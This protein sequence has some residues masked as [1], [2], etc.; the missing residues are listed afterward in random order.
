[1][2]TVS[3]QVN[4][5]EARLREAMLAGDLEMLD[6]LLADDLVFT[7]HTGHRMTKADDLATHKSGR[8]K[9]ERIDISDQRVRP[10]GTGAVVTL[11]AEVAGAYD[12]Q[13]FSATFAYTR[14]WEATDEHWRVAAAH[15]SAIV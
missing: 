8:L 3:D 4:A 5:M 1:M 6:A 11:V 2:I 10:S 15:C 9:I 12:G 13:S 14:V 7:D